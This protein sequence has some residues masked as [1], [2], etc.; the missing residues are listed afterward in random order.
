MSKR[1][2]I[3]Q[4]RTDL[5]EQAWVAAGCPNGKRSAFIRAAASLAELVMQELPQGAG[6]CDGQLTRTAIS[7]AHP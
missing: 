4:V 3:K 6:L 1:V 2:S 7:S 5:G